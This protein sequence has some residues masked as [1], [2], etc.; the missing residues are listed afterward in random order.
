MPAIS[1]IPTTS[2]T[3][4]TTPTYEDLTTSTPL[5]LFLA[6]AESLSGLA[7]KE[8]RYGHALGQFAPGLPKVPLGPPLPGL[9]DR[10]LGGQNLPDV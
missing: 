9:Q 3:R 6:P 2:Q 10:E 7:R 4:A 5:S 8:S 1:D